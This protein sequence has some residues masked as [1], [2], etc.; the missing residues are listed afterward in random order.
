MGSHHPR[1][2]WSD[3]KLLAAV[4][5][6]FDDTWP[7]IRVHECDEDKPRMAELSMK[8]AASSSNSLSMAS[9]TPRASQIG[10]G[11]LSSSGCLTDS[12]GAGARGL[13]PLR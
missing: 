10:F 12:A 7:L 13:T 5:R 9:P 4:T 8:P 2:N 1:P 3:P 11:D 6:A